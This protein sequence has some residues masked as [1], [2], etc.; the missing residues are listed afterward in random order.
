VDNAGDDRRFLAARDALCRCHYLIPVLLDF[1]FT[2]ILAWM[3][4][5]GKP[6]NKTARY[7][8]EP[9]GI[10]LLVFDFTPRSAE[11]PG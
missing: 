11:V 4:M 1:T 10:D 9:A 6:A 7:R 3:P 8:Q 5:E 2:S